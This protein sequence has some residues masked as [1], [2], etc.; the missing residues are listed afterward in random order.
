MSQE[1][2]GKQKPR[3][4][5]VLKGGSRLFLS[6]GVS[7]IKITKDGEPD[8][9]ELAVKSTGITELVERMRAAEPKPPG[10]PQYITPD[11]PVGR[12][13]KLSQKEWVVMPDLTDKEYLAAKEKHDQDITMQV[14]LQALDVEFHTEADEVVEDRD[15]KLRILKEMG[16]SSNQFNQLYSDVQELTTLTDRDRERFFGASSDG[17]APHTS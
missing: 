2:K 16:L 3:K 11:S 17:E 6:T 13:M 9:I 5:S 1:G 4:V 14:I 15:E 12:Q 8:V 10:R 7:R